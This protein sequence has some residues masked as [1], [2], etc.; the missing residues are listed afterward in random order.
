M[1][2]ITAQ[3]VPRRPWGHKLLENRMQQATV[4]SRKTTYNIKSSDNAFNLPASGA[5][6]RRII[7]V[8]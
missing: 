2:I 8:V 7:I 5:G 4:K 1:L 3:I 6:N